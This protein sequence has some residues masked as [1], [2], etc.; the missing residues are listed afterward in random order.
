MSQLESIDKAVRGICQEYAVE[1]EFKSYIINVLE[2]KPALTDE[3][4]DTLTHTDFILLDIRGNSP[5]I[6]VLTETLR[7]IKKTMPDYYKH[8]NIIALVAG[9]SEIRALTK[10][11]K[12]EASNIPVS[13]DN[14][15][16]MNKIPDLSKLVNK[17]MKMMD[18]MKIMGK[19]F[20]FGMLKDASKWVVATEY[21]VNGFAGLPENHKNLLLF[22]LKYYSSVNI[23]EKITPP[24]KLPQFGIYD[25]RSNRFYKSLQELRASPG[26]D[27]EKCV[28]GILFYGGIYFELSLPIVDYLS[29]YL[30]GYNIIPVYAETMDNLNAVTE[31]F[32]DEN[33]KPVVDIVIHLQYFRLNGGPFGGPGDPTLELFKKMNVPQLNPII[34]FDEDIGDYLENNYGLT[35]INNVIAVVMPELDGRF[36]MLTISAVKKGEFSTYIKNNVYRTY[37]LEDTAQLIAERTKKWINLKK[38][39]NSEK[40]IGIILFNYPPGEDNLGNAA[41][42][43]VNRTIHE[44]SKVLSEYGYNC[45]DLPQINDIYSVLLKAGISNNPKYHSEDNFKG[46]TL[47]D[48]E[49]RLLFEKLPL[50]LREVIIKEWGEP[51][52]KV[53]RNSNGIKL[54][55]YSFGN[56][57][58][59]LQPSRS[60]IFEAEKYHDKNLS[61]HHQYVAF[62]RYL[63]E[64]LNLDA[65]IHVGTHGTLELL[66]GKESAGYIGDYN[67]A[68]LGTLPHI[69]FYHIT[70]TSEGSIAKR[71]SNALLIG[72]PSPILEYN[73]QTEQL[74]QATELINHINSLETSPQ[75]NKEI[76]APLKEELGKIITEIGIPLENIENL[77]RLSDLIER[78]KE[79]S[80]PV[81]LHYFHRDYT[82]REIASQICEFFINSPLTDTQYLERLREI[83]G[84]AS[85]KIDKEAILTQ[86][87]SII[88]N[89]ANSE[90]TAPSHSENLKSERTSLESFIHDMYKKFKNT[91]ESSS[92]LNA[93]SAGYIEPGPG[94]DLL[95]NPE[96][97]PA[98]RN[99]YGF[100]PRLIPTTAAY[101]RGAQIAERI[102][103]DYFEEHGEYP[104]STAVILW[105]FET[106]KTGGET[107]GQI[108]SYLGVRPTK[109]KSIWTTEFEI[110]PLE[111]LKRPRID[112]FIQTEGIFRDTLPYILDLINRAVEAVIE[113]DEP[114]EWNFPKKHFNELNARNLLYGQGRI[115]GPSPGSY[116]T[117]ITDLIASKNWKDSGELV[118]NYISSLGYVYLRNNKIHEATDQFKENLKKIAVISQIRD[119]AEYKITDLDHYYEF[120]GGLSKTY[121]IYYK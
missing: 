43:D 117:D 110:I 8:L 39:P 65:I 25:P 96:I 121:E 55:L 2:K 51:P 120:A 79:E 52:G 91:K 44:I 19:I 26:W 9:N 14:R 17:G 105:A 107:I 88:E 60:P 58:I 95:R 4:K 34:Q 87:E 82:N 67:I 94:G 85:E 3:M 32:F 64:G 12:F 106:M 59:A 41:Y 5:V 80:I 48:T 40:K 104:E 92:I 108:F 30:E 13:R 37:I 118:K 56:V 73:T 21:W 50:H 71:R 113:L 93:L 76:I 18:I 57:Y 11:G 27:P 35:P 29:H 45:G 119:S 98:G 97:L 47:S 61:P 16:Y 116:A 7:K 90:T 49:Y 33:Q 78:I 22:L 53:M 114:N 101:I 62:Y 103:K 111:E 83:S 72:Y 70:N 115:F 84:I 66:P 24:K 10:M 109:H 42:L 1:I 100:D 36:E 54:P 102:I 28:V 6:E 81:G 68:L 86:I 46:I 74:E 75:R 112:V 77:S 69:Y 89:T 63:D 15:N 20:P 23:P 38:K 31:Y 99:T